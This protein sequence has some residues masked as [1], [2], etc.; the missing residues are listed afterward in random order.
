MFCRMLTTADTNSIVVTLNTDRKR[1]IRIANAS[2][3]V[4][5]ITICLSLLFCIIHNHT[6]VGEKA[7]NKVDRRFLKKWAQFYNNHILLAFYKFF[8]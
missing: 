2:A 6:K 7:Q 4:L 3:A 1:S 8:R 5:I